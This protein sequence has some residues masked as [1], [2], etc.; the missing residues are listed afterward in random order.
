MKR[1]RRSPGWTTSAATSVSAAPASMLGR[2]S[3]ASPSPRPPR[4]GPRH[5]FS[6]SAARVAASKKA[7]GVS[8]ITERLCQT[9]TGSHA[10][11]N[12]A[13]IDRAGERPEI[14]AAAAVSQTVPAPKPRCKSAIPQATRSPRTKVDGREQ[15]RIEGRTI[16]RRTPV[17]AEAVAGRDRARQGEIIVRIVKRPGASE[18][19]RCTE[20]HAQHDDSPQSKR[21]CYG[22][23]SV[24]CARARVMHI[25]RAW[26]YN[27]VLSSVRQGI[28]RERLNESS[29][30]HPV[31][32][33]HARQRTALLRAA[34]ELRMA[35]ALDPATLQREIVGADG[36]IIRTG[37]V[38]DAALLEKGDKLKVVG[39]HG[40]GYD[41]I[42]VDAATARGIQVVYTPGANTQS[43]AEHVFALM[44]GLS[45]HFP[46]MM[47]GLAAGNYHIR[48]SMT[49]REIAGK[50]LGIIG[51]GRIGRRVAEIAHL[52]FG[53]KVLYHDI[54]AAPAGCRAALECPPRRL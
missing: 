34:T 6:P 30:D 37:G 40:V 16:G 49:G 35:S 31:V 26:L 36:L 14:F 28:D 50:T 42:D 5:P 29:S 51:F 3:A 22:E 11:T 39:R 41:Q 21:I 7:V 52:G 13:K 12:A 32:D 19:R 38:V 4:T 15:E 47:A 2:Q 53:M 46:R 44:I 43:V 23:T 20:K 27:P 25:R 9:R 54:V 18:H 45:R 48:T 1:V 10:V 24:A 8:V 33:E 17:Q